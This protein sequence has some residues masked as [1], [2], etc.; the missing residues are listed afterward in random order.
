MTWPLRG[1]RAAPGDVPHLG[2][3]RVNVHVLDMTGSPWEG[4]PGAVLA[5]RGGRRHHRAMTGTPEG[6]R[7]PRRPAMLDPAAADALPGGYDPAMRNE[8]AHT[9]AAALVHRGR[10]NTDPEVVARLVSLVEREASTWS[11]RCG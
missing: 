4:T 8:I 10:A 7:R 2:P 3:A 11:P 1:P 9:T 6:A 5:G